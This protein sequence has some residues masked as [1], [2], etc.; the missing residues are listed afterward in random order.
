MLEHYFE[1]RNI[2]SGHLEPLTPSKTDFDAK[3]SAKDTCT[4]LG[5]FGDQNWFSKDKTLEMTRNNVSMSKILLK[6]TLPNWKKAFWYFV[7][8]FL[9]KKWLF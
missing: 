9:T 3:T 4:S 5:I 7:S 6:H 1:Y 2:I 8:S